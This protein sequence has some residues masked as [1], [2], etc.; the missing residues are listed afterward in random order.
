MANKWLNNK[1]KI[2]LNNRLKIMV[3]SI[4]EIEHLHHYKKVFTN[5]KCKI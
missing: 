5:L 2:I 3:Q 4:K 1:Q